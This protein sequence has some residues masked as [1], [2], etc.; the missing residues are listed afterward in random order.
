VP[1]TLN[2]RLAVPLERDGRWRYLPSEEIAP[3]WQERTGQTGYHLMPVR[4][5][6]RYR[7]L[8]F[9]ADEPNGRGYP[10]EQIELLSDTHLRS[11]L[12]LADGDRVEIEFAPEAEPPRP[13]SGSP[14]P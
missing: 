6:G 10:P 1:G 5:A 13:A 7:A 12:G 2:L 14:S 3:D 11:A 8:A 9:Q 4:I